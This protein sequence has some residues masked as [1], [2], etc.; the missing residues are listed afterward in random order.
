MSIDRIELKDF[1]ELVD[2]EP[3]TITKDELLKNLRK[4]L[5]IFDLIRSYP[6]LFNNLKEIISERYEK[7]RLRYYP[8]ELSKLCGIGAMYSAN[9]Y[10]FGFVS[11]SKRAEF[12]GWIEYFKMFI[13]ENEDKHTFWFL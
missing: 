8:Y 10:F 3:K 7:D 13:I 2:G 9:N 1:H 6:G 5:D 11:E 4:R 12:E